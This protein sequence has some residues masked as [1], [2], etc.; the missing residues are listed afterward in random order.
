MGNGSFLGW[1]YAGTSKHK[2]E[3]A[4]GLPSTHVTNLVIK[5]NPVRTGQGREVEVNFRAKTRWY[6]PLPSG[7]EFAQE[8]ISPPQMWNYDF[9]ANHQ[10]DVDRFFLLGAVHSQSIGLDDVVVDAIVAAQT[11]GRHQSH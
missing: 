4:G 7:I 5:Y 8:F 1:Y 2:Q 9:P 6:I 10:R 3:D 11:R